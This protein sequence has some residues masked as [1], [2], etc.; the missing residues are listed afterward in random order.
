MAD[1]VFI[2]ASGD[3]NVDALLRGTKWDSGVVTY[4]FPDSLLYYPAD[5]GGSFPL[6]PFE[7]A[8]AAVRATVA[9]ALQEQ[10]SKVANLTFTQV[11]GQSA[12]DTSVAGTRLPGSA[13]FTYIPIVPGTTADSLQRGGD[14]WYD[15]P[16]TARF[17][18]I[19]R[20]DSTW[21]LIMHELGHSVGLNHGHEAARS[22]SGLAT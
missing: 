12:A 13:G 6:F 19:A 10:F 16:E 9:W 15:S 3:Q 4:N 14:F 8:T 18:S 20:G 17:S 21:R 5:Y 1:G 22:V 7:A 11:D 2:T